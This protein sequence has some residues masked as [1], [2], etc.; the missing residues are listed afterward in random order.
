LAP[1]GDPSGARHDSAASQQAWLTPVVHSAPLATQGSWQVPG[2]PRRPEE[3]VQ[4]APE[5]QQG[6]SVPVAQRSPSAA[7][8]GCAVQT[9][10]AP[11]MPG[12][13]LT[14]M[15]ESTQQ[16]LRVPVAQRS[17]VAAQVGCS[18]QTPGAP[19]MPGLEL[20]QMSESTQ[21]GLRVPVAQR[22]PVAAQVGAGPPAGVHLPGAPG[23]PRTLGGSRQTSLEEQQGDWVPVAQVLPVAAQVAEGLGVVHLPLAPGAEEPVAVQTWLAEQQ[24]L[25]T[26]VLQVL[27]LF[28][29][30][31]FL[32]LLEGLLPPAGRGAGW[33]RQ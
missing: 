3:P 17:P 25:R 6:E 20:T 2:P 8:V 21:Q 15:S 10:G 19:G 9:P 16:G 12:L 4:T 7:Q 28:A 14:Q 29:H 27:P 33:G 5:S 13:E 31:G 18:V 1:G 24:A 22:S 32:G 23:M 11:G 30:L 26:P